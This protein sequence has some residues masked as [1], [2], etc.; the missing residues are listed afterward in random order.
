VNVL[1]RAKEILETFLCVI[2][3]FYVTYIEDISNLKHC[4]F[5]IINFVHFRILMSKSF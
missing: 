1:R 5:M 4:T 2:N 3:N